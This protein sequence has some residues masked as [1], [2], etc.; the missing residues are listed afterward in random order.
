MRTPGPATAYITSFALPLDLRSRLDAL[1]MARAERE[2][3]SQPPLR[4]LILE[5][6]EGLLAREMGEV[7]S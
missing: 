2:G 5:G 1:R 6:L 3:G 4:E 7:K